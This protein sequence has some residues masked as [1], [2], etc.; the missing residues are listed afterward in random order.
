VFS[1]L[2]DSS[3]DARVRGLSFFD[4]GDLSVV[5][6]FKLGIDL[7]GGVLNGNGGADD[8]FIGRYAADGTL[9]YGKRFGDQGK[10]A[11]AAAVV[12]GQDFV[13]VAGTFTGDLPLSSS[14]VLT[15]T[16]TAQDGFLVRVSPT[17]VGYAGVHTNGDNNAQGAA[18]AV[19]PGD[20]SVVFIG[21]ITG[22]IDLGGGPLSGSADIFV[23]KF[24][25]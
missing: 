13:F 20:G 1:R 10:D 4:N 5:G 7:G 16:G 14:T 2:L 15:S 23:S 21:A 8:F 3:G 18:V 11:A 6:N 17:G 12:D 9:I 25:P 19:D 24:M 22:T